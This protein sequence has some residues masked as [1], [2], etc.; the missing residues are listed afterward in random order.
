MGVGVSNMVLVISGSG[1][2]TFKS[3][4]DSTGNYI[5]IEVQSGLNPG[6]N[7]T[8]WKDAF[9]TVAA[10]G[11]YGSTYGSSQTFGGNWGITFGTDGTAY[12]GGYV[13]VRITTNTTITGTQI[14]LTAF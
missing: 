11:C 14:Q 2:G 9:R 3:T 4:L 12:S 7:L 5:W 10:G 13:I 8:G 1:S 6:P